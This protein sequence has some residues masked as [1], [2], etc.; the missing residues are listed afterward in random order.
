MCQM[1]K[2]SC[3]FLEDVLLMPTMK[4]KTKPPKTNKIKSQTILSKPHPTI[5]NQSKSWAKNAFKTATTAATSTTDT[6]NANFGH[7]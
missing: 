7:P 4:L 5:N 3:S 1:F 6:N 2:K